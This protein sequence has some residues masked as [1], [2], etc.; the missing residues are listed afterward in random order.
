M[1]DDDNRYLTPLEGSPD[2]NTPHVTVDCSRGGCRMSFFV[3]KSDPRLPD[4]PFLC[5]NHDDVPVKQL[6]PSHVQIRILCDR[7]DAVLTVE[8]KGREAAREAMRAL[9]IVRGWRVVDRLDEL[10]PT[11]VGPP[12]LCASCD[13][14]TLL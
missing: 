5:A 14:S 1:T 6:A 13:R 4:G 10:K 3:A 2:P 9:V 8:A 7:C 12:D 11:A